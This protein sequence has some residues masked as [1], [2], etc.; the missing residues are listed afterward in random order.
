[1]ARTRKRIE[2]VVKWFNGAKGYG[3]I[4][5]PG[6]KDVFL[7]RRAWW[8]EGVPTEGMRVSFVVIDD[9]KGPKAGWCCRP[10]HGFDYVTY[11]HG[12]G[13]WQLFV[14]RYIREND[15]EILDEESGC[16]RSFPGGYKK[17]KLALEP[18]TVKRAWEEWKARQ[19]RE[20]LRRRMRE[21][22]ALGLR[23]HAGDIASGIDGRSHD[24]CTA[25]LEQI[26]SAIEDPRVVELARELKGE[27][28]FHK[29]GW[30][31][32]TFFGG[33][34]NE[35]R[36]IE[37]AE[38]LSGYAYVNPRPEGFSVGVSSDEEVL[39]RYPPLTKGQKSF[40]TL[41]AAA[42]A[43]K[44][45]EI[46]ADEALT[47]AR[48]AR[49]AAK[50]AAENHLAAKPEEQDPLEVVVDSTEGWFARVEIPGFNTTYYYGGWVRRGD[51]PVGPMPLRQEVI[52]RHPDPGVVEYSANAEVG[53]GEMYDLLTSYRRQDA[54]RMLEESEYYI[55]T[56]ASKAWFTKAQ[57][58]IEAYKE[59]HE[60][61][62]E[63][64]GRLIP[65][66]W[67]EELCQAHG[68]DVSYS[69]EIKS[70][71]WHEM[72][73]WGNQGAL[74]DW[75][76][77]RK[78]YYPERWSRSSGDWQRV[79]SQM[80]HYPTPEEI[81]AALTVHAERA[82]QEA[83][84]ASF[85][86]DLINGL[87]EATGL[88]WDD[89]EW[90]TSTIGTTKETVPVWAAFVDGKEVART[91]VWYTKSGGRPYYRLWE[92]QIEVPEGYKTGSLEWRIVGHE[93]ARRW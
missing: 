51:V 74:K 71:V 55:E 25:T 17:Y 90:W 14:E 63:A 75:A 92:D 18:G 23:L 54:K 27:F 43:A 13:E 37:L 9:P 26:P 78:I 10:G 45:A 58:L 87:C 29:E 73:T 38:L 57:E 91:D 59:A 8:D 5:R 22:E 86:N 32:S 53:K 65:K 82:V 46:D 61:I 12:G 72:R 41:M 7:H 89:S 80:L 83:E 42:V 68:I 35:A 48:T 79:G 4:R 81:D 1:M 49:D 16:S 30:S 88:E 40:R 11:G 39:E 77:G 93:P 31:F 56:P 62:W 15:V 44:L 24:W 21:L 36:A 6:G 19:P 20:V 47:A 33:E 70:A 50:E 67:A 28:Y 66:G 84:E 69:D 52:C 34:E 3:F 85:W 76:D 2:G 64:V 60:P